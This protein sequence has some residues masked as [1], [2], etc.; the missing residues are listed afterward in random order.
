MSLQGV[1]AVVSCIPVAGHFQAL[2]MYS[3]GRTDD[4]KKSATRSTAVTAGLAVAVAA[5]P[6]TTAYTTAACVAMVGETTVATVGGAAVAGAATGACGHLVGHTVQSGGEVVTHM[7]DKDREACNKNKQTVFKETLVSAAFGGVLA[8]GAKIILV[9]RNGGF[10]ATNA[11]QSVANAVEEISEEECQVL[12]Y[13]DAGNVIKQWCGGLQASSI[14]IKDKLFEWIP[15]NFIS[16]AGHQFENLITKAGCTKYNFQVGS[17]VCEVDIPCVQVAFQNLTQD[18]FVVAF[19]GGIDS[20]IVAVLLAA[21]HSDIPA[22]H[23]VL[24]DPMFWQRFHKVMVCAEQFGQVLATRAPENSHI[25]IVVDCVRHLKN[26]SA[27]L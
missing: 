22:L 25:P 26:A 7:Q 8:G 5:A 21:I 15:D 18:Q 2:L 20:N 27:M 9:C 6:A 24:T 11:G 14:L 23:L 1:E 3:Q 10:A 4:A 13:Q 12:V 19:L 16:T 17:V